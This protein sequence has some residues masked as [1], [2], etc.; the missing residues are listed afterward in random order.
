MSVFFERLENASIHLPTRYT[1]QKDTHNSQ[2]STT[3]PL[4]GS[5]N[6]LANKV[7][8]FLAAFI[9]TIKAAVALLTIQQA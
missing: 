5:S 6:I 7:P 2:D 8:I 1:A 9:L 4:L 3:T